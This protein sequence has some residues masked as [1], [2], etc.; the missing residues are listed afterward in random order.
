MVIAG[1]F[2]NWIRTGV[3]AGL[4]AA[5]CLSLARWATWEPYSPLFLA[6]DFV[7]LTAAVVAGCALV[8]VLASFVGDRLARAAG[9]ILVTAPMFF[10]WAGIVFK[11]AGERKLFVLGGAAILA[12]VMAPALRR[13][14]D[15]AWPLETL[16]LGSAI[17][18][19]VTILAWP[20]WPA[21]AA[22]TP[23]GSLALVLAGVPRLGIGNSPWRRGAFATALVIAGVCTLTVLPSSRQL[24]SIDL[25]SSPRAGPSVILIVLDTLR[26]DHLS[27][28]GYPRQT[29]PNLD[30][31]AEDALVFVN[32]SSTASW[33]LP[34][35]ASMFTGL[36]PRK[37][38]A[39]GFRGEAQGGNSHG[40]RPEHVSIA[41]LASAAEIE[42]AAI[43]ANHLYVSEKHGLAQ[44][45]GS[46]WSVYPRRGF[47]F[48]PSDWL[49]KTF[50]P[51]QWREFSW[52]YY[53]DRYV[54]DN[55]LRW[56]SAAKGRPFFLFLN[57]MDVHDPSARPAHPE[58]PLEDEEPVWL[59]GWEYWSVIRGDTPLSPRTRRGL[60]NSYD[61]ELIHLDG[62][63]QRLFDFLDDSGLS[64]TTSVFVTS[65]HGEYFGEHGLVKHGLNLHDAVTRVPLIV[66]QPGGAV[67]RIDRPVQS[68]DLF[69]SM[70]EALGLSHDGEVDGRS[71]FGSESSEIVSEWYP[72]QRKYALDPIFEGRFDRTIR[73][74][75]VGK[76]KLL[77]DDRG[78]LVLYDRSQ[79]PQEANDQSA[80]RPE[81][82]ATL[83]ARL[84]RWLAARPAA[85]GDLS[86]E[87]HAL[88]A[89]DLEQLQA[90]GYV[91]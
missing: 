66:K 65:D 53:R 3:S 7:L 5:A 84:D 54:T 39:H 63:L 73:S 22:L 77:A 91:E 13:K 74:L 55:A 57:Y 20:H 19:G 80:T 27:L 15:A 50:W 31:W 33:T 16:C 6:F 62:E 21:A 4:L 78:A 40:L 87:R 71:V 35:H 51:W 89:E 36:S 34:S 45:F 8:G 67:G 61:R 85:A 17:A 26:Q 43:A 10:V 76:L 86:G 79:D 37:H 58:V 82:L 44:G 41:E 14:R 1:T 9:A 47:R 60:I 69:P 2:A 12:I 23:I 48:R 11:S 30:R 88:T 68:N 83:R 75:Q 38:G 24:V 18:T 46:F 59:N 32:S 64:A 29:T 49:F 81:E 70:L 72:S 52:F 42:T 28:Y 56:L 90:L 25:R